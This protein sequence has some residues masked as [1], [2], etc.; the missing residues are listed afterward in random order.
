MPSPLELAIAE[1]EINSDA[2]ALTIFDRVHKFFINLGG[3]GSGKT[4]T[5]PLWALDCGSRGDTSQL[6]GI[7][8]NTDKQMK[9]AVFVEMDSLPRWGVQWDYNHKPSPWFRRTWEGNGIITPNLK[10]Y[11]G[12]FYTSQGVHAVCGTLFN[13]N[14]TQF[15]SLQFASLRV[16]ELT[17]LTLP[18]L[19]AILSRLRCGRRKECAALNHRHQAHMF[20]NPPVGGV[21]PFLFDWLD[22]LEESTKR[23]YHALDAGE[24]CDGCVFVTREGRE[25]PKI[26]GP[27]LSHRQWPLLRRGIGQTILVKSKTSDNRENLDEGYEDDIAMNS[28]KATADAWLGGELTREVTAGCYWNFSDANVREVKYD[29]NRTVYIGIDIN[30]EPRVAVLAHPLIQGEYPTEW[31]QPGVEQI[32]IFGEFFN[33]GGMS[34]RAFAEAMMMGGR[35]SGDAGYL[36]E[37]LRGLPENWLGLLAHQGPIIFYGDAEG[38]RRSA[39]SDNLESSWIIMKQTFRQ[40]KKW[41][42]DVPSNNPPAIA[43]IHSV[44]AK[45]SSAP[46]R[47]GTLGR[48]SLTIAPRCR[49]TIKDCEL[50]VYDEKGTAER[51]WRQGAEMMRTHCM[52]GAGYMI[53]A[54]SPYGK[55]HS[56]R[57]EDY[58]PKTGAA[59]R[60]PPRTSI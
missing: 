15:E 49:H 18:A 28:D 2:Q 13:Q 51:E 38:N 5:H 36:D 58:I 44:C 7:F 12:I 50:V 10:D 56:Q 17:A 41:T 9:D 22:T 54:R 32:G 29:A 1:F 8:T 52:A 23:L 33:L 53:Y 47:D 24:T 60:T 57:P 4:A 37:K 19:S 55:E 16:E 40:L 39:H 43:R 30:I 25:L 27:Q 31:L 20:G 6:H 59:P 34:D 48:P 26:H 45:L 35:G 21:H 11:S 42:V 14:F 3:K 46:L